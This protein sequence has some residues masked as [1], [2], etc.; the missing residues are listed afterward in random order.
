MKSPTERPAI[1]FLPIVLFILHGAAV[2]AATTQETAEGGATPRSE[3]ATPDEPSDEAVRRAEELAFETL[4]EYL[5]A[6]YALLRL[7]CE[8]NDADAAFKTVEAMLGAGYWDFRRLLDDPDLHLVNSTER[9]KSMVRAAW[10]KQYISMLERDSRDEMQQPRRVLDALGVE[11]GEVVAD[12][13]AGSGYFTVLLADAV[14]PKG[15]VI[16]TDIRQ[17]MLDYLSKRLGEAGIENVELVKVEADDPGLPPRAITTVLMVDVMHYVKDRAAF[18]RK[19]RP[20]LAPG[21]RL[22]IIDFRYDPE[23]EREF[24]PPPRQQV[25]RAVLDRDM[26]EAG[27]EVD[28]SFDFLR[29]Q[30]FV[31]YRAVD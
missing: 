20:A 2:V 17:E 26:A 25:P 18:A 11:P 14:G 24:A 5:D 31:I 23:A 28:T 21:G 12:V 29:E 10:T 3:Q 4:S 22:A 9:L 1:L 13:G 30:Y 16:A 7:H 19:L 8:R 27:F 15:R 6:S